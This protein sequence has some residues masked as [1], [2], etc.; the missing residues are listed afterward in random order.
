MIEVII[1]HDLL[2]KLLLKII[3]MKHK[4]LKPEY[5]QYKQNKHSLEFHTNVLADNFQNISH[6]FIY[7]TFNWFP[8]KIQVNK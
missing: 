7:S 5:L 4:C 3:D 8:D 1:S 6:I 2:P